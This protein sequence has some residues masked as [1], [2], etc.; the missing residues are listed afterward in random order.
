MEQELKQ[1]RNDELISEKTPEKKQSVFDLS[2]HE[3]TFS[4]MTFPDMSFDK[5]LD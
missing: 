3:M 1:T 5:V 4:D 2:F